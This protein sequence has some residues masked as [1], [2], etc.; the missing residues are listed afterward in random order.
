[1]VGLFGIP[2]FLLAVSSLLFGVAFLVSA[3]SGADPVIIG[4]NWRRATKAAVATGSF[5]LCALL[6]LL[7]NH[8]LPVM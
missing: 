6:A 4:T 1:M 2:C 7:G 8:L 3:V 5:V